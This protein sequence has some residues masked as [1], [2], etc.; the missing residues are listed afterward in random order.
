MCMYIIKHIY[1]LNIK[2]LRVEA[3]DPPDDPEDGTWCFHCWDLGL[4]P[5]RG[6]RISQGV[7]CGQ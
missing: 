7:W 4:I 1:Y 5:G 6:T 3:V 2:I